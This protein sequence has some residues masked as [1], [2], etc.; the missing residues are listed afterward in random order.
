MFLKCSTKNGPAI[1]LHEIVLVI[2]SR[3]M[4]DVLLQSGRVATIRNTLMAA[5]NVFQKYHIEYFEPA[6]NI[7]VIR[8]YIL[9]ISKSRML[10]LDE[11][12]LAATPVDFRKEIENLQVSRK[13]CKEFQSSANGNAAAA[14]LPNLSHTAGG[15]LTILYTYVKTR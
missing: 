7:I 6:T 15:R 14:G 3:N 5:R 12:V 1:P 4:M 2:H 9:H 8:K 11:T 10:M 13:R